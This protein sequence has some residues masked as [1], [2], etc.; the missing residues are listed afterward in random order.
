MF[1][2]SENISPMQHINNIQRIGGE[3]NA[4][5]AF[6][7]SFSY[8]TVPSSQLALVLWLE[9]D[10]MGSLSVTGVNLERAKETLMAEQCQRLSA[11]PYLESFFLFDE[12][13]FAD[14]VYGYPHP[15]PYEAG[16]Y[17]R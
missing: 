2:G 14:F 15:L 4:N 13:L 10:R 11:E 12:I 6:D 16:G 9:S 7:K 3:F 17:W 5:T 1:Q 8:Q